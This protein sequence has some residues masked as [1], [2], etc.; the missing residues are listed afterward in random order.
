MDFFKIS[1]LLAIIFNVISCANNYNQI[2]QSVINGQKVEKN[3]IVAKSTVSILTDIEGD[4]QYMC[5]GTLISPRVIIT[6]THCLNDIS[7][8]I[9]IKE[10][11]YVYFGVNRPVNF[12]VKNIFPIEKYALHPELTEIPGQAKTAET[13]ARAM[14]VFKQSDIA[15]IV[16]NQDAPAGYEPVQILENEN[17]I[18]IGDRLI[19]AGVGSIG[20]SMDAF[21]INMNQTFIN[22]VGFNKN[23]MI[24]DQT[25]NTGVCHGDSGGPAYLQTEK[26]LVLVGATKGPHGG[27]D[28]CLQLGEFTLIGVHQSVIMEMLAPFKLKS[29]DL[30]RFVRL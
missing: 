23:I 8:S 4:P 20:N 12:N 7:N 15:V 29:V 9:D 18:K 24:V 30:P 22:V 21:A 17:F 14:E 27:V 10:T 1:F 28:T 5:T 13:V 26:G 19:A 25:K 2:S 3:S 16:L 11:R 6:A